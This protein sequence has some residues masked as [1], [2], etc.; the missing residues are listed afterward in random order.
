MIDKVLFI[1]SRAIRR[2]LYVLF[3]REE[4]ERLKKEKRLADGLPNPSFKLE[5]P[6]HK[7]NDDISNI[8]DAHFD[9]LE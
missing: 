9:L 2:E 7:I 8:L 3:L 6:R 4:I 1:L 5:N